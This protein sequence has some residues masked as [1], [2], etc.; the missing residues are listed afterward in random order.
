[1]RCGAY[2]EESASRLGIAPPSP[3]PAKK[4]HSSNQERSGACGVSSENSEN[5]TTE[6]ASIHLRP[7]RS[8]SGPKMNAPNIAPSR[9]AENTC[10]KAV[11]GMFREDDIAVAAKPIAC[12]SK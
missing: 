10:P 1:M 12:V 7:K 9:P 6:P 8:A 2:S 11:I 3:H 5:T 4:R